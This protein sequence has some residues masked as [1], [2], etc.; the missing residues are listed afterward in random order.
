[1][2][3]EGTAT[4]SLQ[5]KHAISKVNLLKEFKYKVAEDLLRK[6]FLVSWTRGFGLKC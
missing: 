6:E 2:N 3:V 4:V 1:M 5:N